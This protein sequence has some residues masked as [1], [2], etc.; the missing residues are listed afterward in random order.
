MILRKGKKKKN[1]IFGKRFSDI[2][3]ISPLILSSPDKNA[4]HSPRKDRIRLF[5]I[6]LVSSLL[7]AIACLILGLAFL[8]M[9]SPQRYED[10]KK[11]PSQL[12]AAFSNWIYSWTEPV[13]IM[14]LDIKMKDIQKME[15]QRQQALADFDR[16]DFSFVSGKLGWKGEHYK[17]NIRLKGDR[18][19]HFSDPDQ[20]SFRIK[21]KEGKA[22]DGMRWFSLHRPGA[23]NYLYEWLFHELLNREGFAH[24]NY[25]FL[26]LQLNGTDLGIYALEEHFEKQV[27]ERAGFREGPI[28]RLDES[29]SGD[30]LYQGEWI[31]YQEKRWLTPENEP[32]L[33]NAVQLLEGF[34]QGKLKASEVFEV[35]KMAHFFALTDLLKMNHAGIWKSM[36]FY[37]N[38]ITGK[39]EPIGYDGHLNLHEPD[40]PTLIAEAAFEGEAGW[41]SDFYQ[42][43]FALF[44]RENEP[45]DSVFFQKYVAALEEVSRKEYLDQFL[46]SVQPELNRNLRIIRKD[47]FLPA[48]HLQW[49]GPDLHSFSTDIF[50]QQQK[51][52]RKVLF[53]QKGG[54]RGFKSDFSNGRI[55]ISLA[56]LTHLPISLTGVFSQNGVIDASINELIFPAEKKNAA[57]YQE[58]DISIK[59]S[60]N[61]HDSLWQDLFIRYRVW[62][63]D[64][65]F[66]QQIIPWRRGITEDEIGNSLSVFKDEF[67][68]LPFIAV[69]RN[70][71]TILIKPGTWTLEKPIL[72]PKQYATVRISAGTTL[73]LIEG[74]F[75]ISEIPL[76]WRGEE[77]NPIR[78]ISSDT[79]GKGV[80]VI[81]AGGVSKLSNLYIEGQGNP[82]IFGRNITGA[83]SF[84]QSPV[85]FT[86]VFVHQNY[87]EDA[88]NLIRSE[89]TMEKVGISD[90]QFDGVDLDFCEGQ[91]RN[92][93]IIN[94][95]N[96]GIDFSGSKVSVKGL[97]V[98]NSGDKG[99]SIG[100]ESDIQIDHL[101]I[102][103]ALMG[104][105]VKD[106][107]VAKINHVELIDS[108]TGLGI[109]EKK[110]EYGGGKLYLSDVKF[111]NIQTK[112]LIDGKSACIL[113]GKPIKSTWKKE[114]PSSLVE[115]PP[116]SV[117]N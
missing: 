41:Y 6:A 44:F 39:L 98:E 61:W 85:N 49:Y 66:S 42:P 30:I 10:L 43:W 4:S 28:I 62:G 26:R 68:Q 59:N 23:R 64:T 111:R 70:T 16:K 56:N 24:L 51:L 38:P 108:R 81:N 107:S 13:E 97:Y 113:H 37:Y 114:S 12:P 73:D 105:A 80:L 33:E 58:I 99:V 63:T 82:E 11:L 109:Y 18:Y 67:L 96:D 69:D 22:L 90:A 19:V 92:L 83:V 52:I 45:L 77:E 53:P 84:Y 14:V 88:I 46:L 86:A 9:L 89:F 50:Y 78:L 48:D 1:L 32:L 100:E 34:R 29:L 55:R 27:V 106:L 76:L 2:I 35:D 115:P 79:T 57:T 112:Y 71:K 20:W 7:T 117:R 17:I 65:V 31:P 40:A 110:P 47:F 87:S 103:K 21:L 101:H 93:K 72:F 94:S 116:S 15:Y 74:A 5:R 25:Q 8:R 91:I 75:I 95:G 60:D 102:K 36:R 3:K 104:V 54:L